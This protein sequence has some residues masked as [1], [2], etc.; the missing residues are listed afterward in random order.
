L[1]VPGNREFYGSSRHEGLD[2]AAK[3]ELELGDK[4]TFMHR[5]KVE[6]ND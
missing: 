3:F 4:F 1:L 2:L 5:K 6:L